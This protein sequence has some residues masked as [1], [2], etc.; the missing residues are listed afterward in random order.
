MPAPKGNKYAVGNSG[1]PKIF[2]TPEEM[3]E[4]IDEYYAACDNNTKKIWSEKVGEIVEIPSPIPYTV[5]GLCECLD[6]NRSTLLTYETSHTHEDFNN[7]VKRAKLKIQKNT[8]EMAL[9]GALNPAVSIFVMKNNFNYKDK[10]ETDIT[11]DGEKINNTI[12]VK[13]VRSKEDLNG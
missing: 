6:I 7:T 11:T 4:A 2:E 8:A 9:M 10:T 3:Q 13:V 12:N 5:E 1:R